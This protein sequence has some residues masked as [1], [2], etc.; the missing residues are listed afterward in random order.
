MRTSVLFNQAARAAMLVALAL[1]SCSDKGTGESRTDTRMVIAVIPKGTTHSFWKAIHAGAA[2]ASRELSVEVIWKGPARE[3]DREAQIAE[4]ENFVSRGV[5]GIVL[6]PTDEKAL[7][8]PVANA[9]RSG[10]PV[11]I[12]DSDLD[13][14]DYVSFVATDNYEGGRLAGAHMVETLGGRG[15]VVMLRYMEGSASTMRREQ[16]FLDIIAE[17]PGIELVSSNQYAGA[18][19]ETAYQAS[20]NLLARFKSA[21][22]SL[23]ID[24]I[25][26]PNESSSFGMLRALQDAAL[27]GRVTLIGFDASE[28]MVRALEEGSFEALVL[29]D[30]VNMAYLGVKTM[31]DHLRGEAVESRIDT[32]V[33]LITRENMNEPRMQELL[34]PDIDR[35][36]N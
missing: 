30:P 18:T 19:A 22:G 28:Q 8:L 14:D 36:L 24:G 33:T 31:V 15:R 7:R 9:V 21:D 3:D 1:G 6:A 10:I 20:E 32:G 17:S 34:R 23:S 5:S 26:C 13:S 27:A 12:I 35:W 2:K 29:Q 11:V 25:Y 4:V 16:G